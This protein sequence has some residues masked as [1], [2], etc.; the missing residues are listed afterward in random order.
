MT[1][2]QAVA[3]TLLYHTQAVDPTILTAL[4]AIATK[5][6]KPTQE[7]MKKVKQLLDHCAT[8]EDVM[9]TYNA[10]KMIL[11]VHSDAGYANKKNCNAEPEDISSC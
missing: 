9:I 1:Y 6:A 5:Q 7:T 2:V 8:Q 11:A 3:G 4:S 10:S